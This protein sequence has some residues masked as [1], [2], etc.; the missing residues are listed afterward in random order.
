MRDSIV[1]FPDYC[2]FIYFS[3]DVFLFLQESNV[4]VSVE[5]P[6][7]NCIEFGFVGFA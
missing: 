1:P 2:L 7:M 4:Y 6:S 5:S 3:T